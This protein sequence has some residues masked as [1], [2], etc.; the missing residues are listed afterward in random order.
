MVTPSECVEQGSTQTQEAA[1]LR[2]LKRYGAPVIFVKD[3]A[4][5]LPGILERER[6]LTLKDKIKRRQGMLK[7]Y[8]G[9]KRKLRDHF[10][11]VNRDTFELG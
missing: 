9:F 3:W 7:W 10:V 1:P 5:E 8:A 6:S 11:T 2:L 4:T